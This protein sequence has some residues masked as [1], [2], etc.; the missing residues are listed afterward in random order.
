MMSR[1]E[2]LTNLEDV[3]VNPNLLLSQIK[4]CESPEMVVSKYKYFCSL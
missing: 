3:G 4:L 2:S 1:T